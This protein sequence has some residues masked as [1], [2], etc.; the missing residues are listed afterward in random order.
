MAGDKFR[1]PK[2]S[3]DELV[4][5]IK[6]YAQFENPVSLGEVSRQTGLH[7]TIISKNVGF[8]L[9]TGIL[10]GGSKKECTP[11]GMELAQALMHDMSEEIRTLWRKTVE[12]SEFL[13]RTLAAVRIRNGMDDA[14]I[15]GHIAY[16]AGQKKNAGV[17]TGARSVVDV[18]KAAELLREQDGK[19][20]A[21]DML[22]G[23]D[24]RA[25]QAVPAH[26]T[27][28][29][30]LEQRPSI[31]QTA[32]SDVSLGLSLNITVNVECT[33]SD[34]DGLGEKLRQVIAEVSKERPEEQHTHPDKGE[35]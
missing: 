12:E 5:V 10:Q 19:L 22:L 18:L 2:S 3:Y 24:S 28:R 4:K 35:E 15:T 16:S 25:G 7:S 8:L 30:D 31:A 23:S 26:M 1:L 17:M 14:T 32:L 34:L 21:V 20:T 9:D 33:P 6:G 13:S 11:T 29:S 27:E